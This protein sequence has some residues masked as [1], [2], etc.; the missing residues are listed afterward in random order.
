MFAYR[1]EPIPENTEVH[2]TGGAAGEEKETR[3]EQEAVAAREQLYTGARE[4]L[5][6]RV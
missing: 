6:A 4:F 1:G 2:L 5:E 3:A